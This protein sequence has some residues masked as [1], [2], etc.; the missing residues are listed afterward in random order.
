MRE[1]SLAI[2]SRGMPH[3]RLAV[4]RSR[5]CLNVREGCRPTDAGKSTGARATGRDSWA[6]SSPSY[7]WPAWWGARSASMTA[8]GARSC[9][10]P[11][12]EHARRRDGLA[13]PRRPTGQSG[14]KQA[15]HGRGMDGLRQV[16]V[17]AG[18]P[19]MAL[20]LGQPIAGQGDEV[21]L[22]AVWR[23]P[24]A[25]GNLVSV[26]AG[27][28]DVD[29]GHVG[30]K[31]QHQ[32]DS[33][34]AIGGLVNLVAVELEEHA[35]GLPRVGVVLDES[36]PPRRTRGRRRRRDAPRDGG[37]ERGK[38][39]REDAPGARAGALRVHGT[40]VKLDEPLDQG[41][42]DPEAAA[43]AIQGA[44]ALDEPVEDAREEHGT[45]AHAAVLHPKHRPGSLAPDLDVNRAACGRVA[46]GVLHEIEHHLLDPRGVA[47]DPHGLTGQ[48][49]GMITDLA[50]RAQCGQGVIGGFVE[51]EGAAGELD[52]ARHDPPDVEEVVD[53]SSELLHLAGDDLAG[54]RGGDA[55]RIIDAVQAVHGIAD[56]PQRVAELVTQHGQEL[57]LEPVGRP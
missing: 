7:S 2:A 27:K 51:V 13:G 29:E 32:L 30:A 5:S 38:A 6:P 48:G 36:D 19:G 37:G 11:R 55:V 9:V 4:G 31:P 12:G 43:A 17:E 8:A 33:R 20:V 21:E 25:L 10:R 34:Q 50:G 54:V 56:G 47:V 18:L 41:Q 57:V 24:D 42:A 52:L 1:A 23:S 44:L 53:Q 26:D 49:D 39:D 22:L 16:S 14:L 28:T 45:Y 40:A 15:L 46:E 3:A 35:K